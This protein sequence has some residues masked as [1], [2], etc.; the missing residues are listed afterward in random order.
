M[1]I[2]LPEDLGGAGLGIREATMMLQTI[3]EYVDPF[4]FYWCFF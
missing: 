2:A 4:D 3:S 1:G